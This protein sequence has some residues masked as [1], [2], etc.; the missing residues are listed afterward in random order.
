MRA[1]MKAVASAMEAELD[2][3]KEA[4][5]L[6]AQLQTQVFA[7]DKLEQY[8]RKDSVRICGLPEREDERY[9]DS[10]Q[11][12]VELGSEMGLNI[13]L[14]MEVS[15]SHRLGRRQQGARPRPIIAKFER[16]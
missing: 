1:E 12:V 14:A 11:L 9:K 15:V 8:E 10:T 13:S 6:R 2:N 7:Q 16:R 5:K 4:G 3:M